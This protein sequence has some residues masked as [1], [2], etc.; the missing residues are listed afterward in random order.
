MR[1]L[2]FDIEATGLGEK[3]FIIEFAA[4]PFDASTGILKDSLS[5]RTLVRCPSF[6]KLRPRLNSWVIENNRPLIEKAHAEGM[7]LEAFKE[8]VTRYLK[9]GPMV[10]YFG[11]EKPIL[12]GKS[13]A[14]IDIPFLKRDLGWDWFEEH[15]SHR[16]LD[17]SAVSYCLIDKGVLP[18][19]C[20]T[21]SGLMN[22][23]GMG[24]VAHTA[25][26][27][28]RNTALMYLKL[29]GVAK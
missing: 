23:L 1:Y 21:G 22:H 24:E 8:E 19:S 10:E 5:W 27:D 3:D 15:F 4:L 13:V 16:Q 9:S 2:S 14:S 29:I 26:E 7:A 12:F 6:E 28:A 17:L 20:S 11:G 25:L 18:R